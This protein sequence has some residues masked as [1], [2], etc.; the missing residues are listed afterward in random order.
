M[1]AGMRPIGD[2]CRVRKATRTHLIINAGLVRLRRFFIFEVF[3]GNAY[4]ELI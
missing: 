3:M 2:H 1:R 4:E